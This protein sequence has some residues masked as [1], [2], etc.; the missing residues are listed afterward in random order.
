MAGSHSSAVI[1][2][3]EH[4]CASIIGCITNNTG[5]NSEYCFAAIFV[6]TVGRTLFKTGSEL[7]SALAVY[8]Q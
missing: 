1:N 2:I 7:T 6:H 8:E 3:W 5:N 4:A